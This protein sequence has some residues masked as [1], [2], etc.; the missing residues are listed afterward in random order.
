MSGFVVDAGRTRR[1]RYS[2]Q[3]L[4]FCAELRLPLQPPS[5]DS[6]SDALFLFTGLS[7]RAVG[8]EQSPHLE[9]HSHHRAAGRCS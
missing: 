1:E 7:T 4:L 3:Q 2:C 9:M 5:T 6:V 8:T